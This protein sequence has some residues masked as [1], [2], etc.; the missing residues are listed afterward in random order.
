MQVWQILLVIAGAVAFLFT[1]MYFVFDGDD[2][3]R[4]EQK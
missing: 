3:P 4:P 1:V 2:G